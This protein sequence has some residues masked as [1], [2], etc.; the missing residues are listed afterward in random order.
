MQFGP[1]KLATRTSLGVLAAILAPFAQAVLPAAAMAAE[2]L[3]GGVQIELCTEQGAKVALLGADGQV[4]DKGFAGLPRHDC[5]AAS[6]A[7]ITVHEL[8]VMPVACAVEVVRHIAALPTL[9]PRTRPP[10]R[11]WASGPRIPRPA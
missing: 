6:L 11:P 9:Q 5:L 8:S 10:S 2:S 4:R 7:V 1:K 3:G